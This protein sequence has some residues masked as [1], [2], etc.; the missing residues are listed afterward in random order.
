[1]E[2]EILKVSKMTINANLQHNLR[3]ATGLHGRNDHTMQTVIDNLF[4]YFY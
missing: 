4:P 1:M 3:F 2:V